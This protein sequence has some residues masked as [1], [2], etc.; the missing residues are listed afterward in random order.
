MNERTTHRMRIVSVEKRRSHTDRIAALLHWI[1]LP[2]ASYCF[3]SDR[4]Q[5]TIVVRLY[6]YHSAGDP[7][8]CVCV[9]WCVLVSVWPLFYAIYVH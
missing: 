8:T 7:I 6:V 2:L 5:W 9:S 4:M 3:A 1:A